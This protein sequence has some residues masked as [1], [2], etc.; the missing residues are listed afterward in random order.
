[1]AS[2]IPYLVLCAAGLAGKDCDHGHGQLEPSLTAAGLTPS[3]DT[4]GFVKESALLSKAELAG[5]CEQDNQ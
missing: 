5:S 4:V 1:M 2:V 3:T